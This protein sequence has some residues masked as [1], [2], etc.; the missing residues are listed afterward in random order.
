M[1]VSACILST[2][3]VS[4]PLPLYN[5]KL[6]QE[7]P[8]KHSA[9]QYPSQVWSAQHWRR[10]GG[11]GGSLVQTSWLDMFIFII[12]ARPKAYASQYQQQALKHKNCMICRLAGIWPITARCSHSVIGQ[13]IAVHH[14]QDAHHGIIWD[15]FPQN[16]DKF[17]GNTWWFLNIFRVFQEFWI[18]WSYLQWVI[19][20]CTTH[21]GWV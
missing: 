11:G 13:S 4:T 19:P 17:A 21:W 3:L 10:G 6:Q 9:L 18:T 20:N 16:Q 8:W 5:V 14:A 7:F 15:L 1:C 2:A 12:V